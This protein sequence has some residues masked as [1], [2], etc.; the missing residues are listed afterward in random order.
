MVMRNGIRIDINGGVIM[1]RICLSALIVVVLCLSFSCG[2]T[3]E[4]RG[5]KYGGMS[6]VEKCLEDSVFIDVDFNEI[7][8]EQAVRKTKSSD[9]DEK[10]VKANAAIYRFYSHVKIENGY[11]V[12]DLRSHEE[13][14][15]SASVFNSLKSNL[16]EI[17]SYIRSVRDSGD[18]IRLQ[19]VDEA[20]LN[21]LL[22]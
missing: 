5:A 10:N 4:S 22:K 11:Y 14:N 7:A 15:V 17:N 21:S 6:R 9:L 3:A 19:S 13:I 2:R 16:E 18:S 20:Y 12:C 8:A 1:K